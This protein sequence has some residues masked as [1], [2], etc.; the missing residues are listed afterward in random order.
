VKSL[1]SIVH[2]DLP[3]E[4][5]A[6]LSFRLERPVASLRRN[7]SPGGPPEVIARELCCRY[8][9]AG[10]DG[11]RIPGVDALDAIVLSES[12]ILKMC[13]KSD[14]SILQIRQDAPVIALPL[15]EARHRSRRRSNG[16]ESLLW[17]RQF[18]PG[19]AHARRFAAVPERYVF[20]SESL[21]T[22]ATVVADRV[23]KCG[24]FSKLI[25]GRPESRT[26]VIRP[27]SV[28]LPDEESISV[29][30]AAE[31]DRLVGTQPKRRNTHLASEF[32]GTRAVRS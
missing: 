6:D 4:T 5:F 26:P 17:L 7:L 14:R 16:C 2:G 13:Y 12:E 23:G 27:M 30:R 31:G 11:L 3:Q 9:V 29:L 28:L 10:R 21:C 32:F 15:A 22:S 24:G 20:A 1:K 18:A 8:R 25:A 19:L